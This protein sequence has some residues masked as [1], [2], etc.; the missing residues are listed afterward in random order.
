MDAIRVVDVW[1]V[2]LQEP[3]VAAKEANLLL[4]AQLEQDMVREQLEQGN[5]LIQQ[6][7]ERLQNTER[8]R[9]IIGKKEGRASTGAKRLIP[10]KRKKKEKREVGREKNIIGNGHIDIRI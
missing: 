2:I 10:K 6:S 7:V 5:R 4:Q 1:Q 8:Q 9:R 3:R